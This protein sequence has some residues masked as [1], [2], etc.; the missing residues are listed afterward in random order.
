VVLSACN[1]SLG[2]LHHGEGVMSL[3]RSFFNS[4]SHSVMPTLWEVND[5]TS[6]ELIKSFYTNLNLG[7]DKSLALHNAKLKYLD[8][9]SLSQSS[10]YYWASFVLIGDTSTIKIETGSYIIY[11]FI[12]GI[13]LLITI[14][15]FLRRKKS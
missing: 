12:F 10:P 8:V 3:S 15:Y 6:L 7:Q 13:I 4:G 11:Y 9:N 14:I 2:E 1:T 5:K